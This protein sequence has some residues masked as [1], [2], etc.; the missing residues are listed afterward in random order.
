MT[1]ENETRKQAEED[2]QEDLELT[3]EDAGEVTGG[4][5]PTS[6]SLDA[7]IH[8]KYDIKAQKEA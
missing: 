5:T 7:G 1:E 4:T 8:F 2:A 3:D 6:G